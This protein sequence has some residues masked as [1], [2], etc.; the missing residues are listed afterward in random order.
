[1]FISDLDCLENEEATL[2]DGILLLMI[3]TL[4]MSG[5]Q[6]GDII[7]YK[8]RCKVGVRYKHFA[9]YVGDVNICGKKAGQDIYEQAKKYHG[10]SCK[11]AKLTMNEEP[12]V[13][14]YL[15]DYTDP[16]TGETYIKGDDKDIIKRIIETYQNCRIYGILHNNCEHIATYVRYGV[17]VALQ[18]NMTGEGLIFG[19]DKFDKKHLL[20]HLRSKSKC[21]SHHKN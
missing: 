5:F 6:F 13:N 20:E 16:L 18:L 8:T 21:P 2:V 10:K 14:N 12:E 1:M 17:R 9:V 4:E 15:D 7:S 3:T 19:N 11:F